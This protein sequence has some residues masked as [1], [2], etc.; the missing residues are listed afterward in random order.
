MGARIV[1]GVLMIAVLLVMFFI[2]NY[3]FNFILLG[4]V[5]YFAFNE[6]LKLYNIEHDKLVYVAL[7]FYV[8]TF[9]TNP[10]FIAILAIML[11]ASVLAHIK[12][13]D[14]RMVLPFIYPATPIFMMWMLYSEYGIGFLVWL[15]FG[16]AASDTAAY[17][18]GKAIGK[19]KFSIA[20]P[21]KT[22]EGVAGGIAAGTAVGIVCGSFVMEGF[23]Q[24]ICA[25]FLLSIFGVW[26]DLF[27]SYLKRS[28]DVKDSG[29]IFPGHGGMLDRVDGYLF[30]VVAL[31]WTL[32]W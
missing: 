30:G 8:L 26:G 9:F 27:E 5:L 23:L 10:I 13:P 22:L 24:I 7:V 1:T 29:N 32:S 18:V 2:N 25:S 20:S 28:A 3:I 21:N 17:F 19:R 12:S 11:V 14:L 6:S 4:A 16:V 15:I 31:L